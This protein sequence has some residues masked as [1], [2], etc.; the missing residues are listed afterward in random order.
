MLLWTFFIKL[1]ICVYSCKCIYRLAEVCIHK[2]LHTQYSLPLI[3]IW[4]VGMRSSRSHMAVILYG[5]FNIPHVKI[6]LDQL[7][8]ACYL[9]RGLSLFLQLSIVALFLFFTIILCPYSFITQTL[10]LPT[11]LALNMSRGINSIN[12]KI[13]GRRRATF[14]FFFF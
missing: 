12:Y 14:P 6:N 5:L 4:I 13:L 1:Y 11:S 3:S 10:F 2:R 7:L 8:W 9:R